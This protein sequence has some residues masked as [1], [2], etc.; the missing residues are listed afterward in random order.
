MSGMRIQ[1]AAADVLMRDGRALVLADGHVMLLSELSSEI[2]ALAQE[3]VSVEEVASHLAAVFGAPPDGIDAMEQV[4]GLI[5]E[6]ADAGVVSVT[7]G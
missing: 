1:V 6:L 3:P 4:R 7:V 2:V 5:A